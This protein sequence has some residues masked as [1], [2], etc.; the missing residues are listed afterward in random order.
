MRIIKRE[1]ARIRHEKIEKMRVE[2]LYK[3]GVGEISIPIQRNRR[4]KY[5]ACLETCIMYPSIQAV[6]LSIGPPERADDIAKNVATACKHLYSCYGKHYIFVVKD[7]I[8]VSTS[9]A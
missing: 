9:L 7:L 5:V 6:A 8:E 1:L 2:F 3:L 4:A